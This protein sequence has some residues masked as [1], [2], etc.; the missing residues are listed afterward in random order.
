[1]GRARARGPRIVAER[2]RRVSRLSGVAVLL[3]VTGGGLACGEDADHRPWAATRA[4]EVRELDFLREVESTVMTRAEYRAQAADRA[5]ALDEEELTE[6]AETYGRLGF[7]EVDTDL[8]PIFAASSD[9]VGA[10]YSA[11]DERITLVQDTD[12][13]VEAYV[14]VHE[15]IHALQDQH[16][17]LQAYDGSTS[18]EFIAR[19]AVVEGDATLAELRFRAQDEH[20]GELDGWDWPQ[21]LFNWHAY[22]DEMLASTPYPLLFS[23]YP[24]FAYPFGLDY[25]AHNL[26][27]AGLGA[28]APHQWSRE[29]ELFTERPPQTSQ[30]VI[31]REEDVDEITLVGLDAVP[32]PLSD[33]LEVID[34][35]TLGE[36]Y[37][38]L[39]LYP[40]AGPSAARTVAAGWD[41]DR[42]LFVSDPSRGGAVGTVWASAWDDEVVAGEVASLLRILH[43]RQ[44]VQDDPTPAGETLWLEQRGNLVVAIRNLD[45]ELIPAIADAAFAPARSRRSQRRRPPLGRRGPVVEI[46]SPRR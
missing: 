28:R 17:D 1:M 19:R 13:D 37:V 46:S 27:G 30:Q 6:M 16:F 14:E 21:L 4:S 41:G 5:E 45:A 36:W 35:D 33:R 29:D 44:F 32:A 22:G 24:A 18:D 40:A 23:D 42:V 7:F 3:L 10:T 39:L 15:Y 31:R 11:R 25:T 2:V 26:L 34:W 8:R 20:A 12:A 43:E 9:W 38:Y